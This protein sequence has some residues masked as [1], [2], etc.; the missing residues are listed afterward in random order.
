MLAHGRTVSAAALIDDLWPDE[1]P[2][3]P[4]AALQSLVSRTR[5]HL[6]EGS[7]RP[8]RGYSLHAVSDLDVARDQARIA[9]ET[10]LAGDALEAARTARSMLDL[11]RASPG[12]PAGSRG[13]RDRRRAARR[14]R[15][16]PGRGRTGSARCAPR[17]RRSPCGRRVGRAGRRTLA[18]RRGRPPR[19]PE[20]L[21]GQRTPGRRA[22]RVRRPP[23]AA[24]H[25][26]GH[27]PSR[28]PGGAQHPDPSCRR[29]RPQV[30]QRARRRGRGRLPRTGTALGLRAAP[31]PSSG[32]RPTSGRSSTC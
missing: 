30:R 20:G 1:Q 9:A 22:A 24:R 8:V 3:D 11:W 18:A 32:A 27:R 16:S 25:R 23:D 17:R 19:P 29:A 5:S 31:N 28:G 13:L 2:A 21:R 15:A 6:V 4:R 10:L 26:A 14:R 7:S 12:G